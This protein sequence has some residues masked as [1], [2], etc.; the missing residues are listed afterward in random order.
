MNTSRFR[1]S[2]I[3][4]MKRQVSTKTMS[5]LF[6]IPYVAKNKAA[7]RDGGN[8]EGSTDPSGIY[9]YTLEA[10]GKKIEFRK[11]IMQK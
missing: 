3:Y 9:F 11:M 2:K 7:S 1:I 4:Q 8:D 5:Y 10:N 6:T